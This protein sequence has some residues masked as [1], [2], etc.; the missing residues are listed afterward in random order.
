[1]NWLRSVMMPPSGSEYAGQVDDIYFLIFWISTVF[2]FG[3]SGES[4]GK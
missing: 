1:M 3:S 4:M 2:F